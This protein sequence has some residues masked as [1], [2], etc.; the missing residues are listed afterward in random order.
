MENIKEAIK[1]LILA[2]P[3]KSLINSFAKEKYNERFGDIIIPTGSF[4]YY[5]GYDIIS[6]DKIKIEFEY[7]YGDMV[8]NDSFS[9]YIN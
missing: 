3:H 9:V 7:G 1:T 8:F 4:H 6:E 2:A 5:S